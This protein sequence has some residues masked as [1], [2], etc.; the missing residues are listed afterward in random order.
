MDKFEKLDI[1]IRRLKR[2]G[3]DI[4]LSGNFPWIYLYKINN[5][6]VQERYHANHGHLIGFYPKDGEHFKFDDIK[7]LFKTIRRYCK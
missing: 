6:T 1:F 2:L 7:H 4:E 5:K 3:V